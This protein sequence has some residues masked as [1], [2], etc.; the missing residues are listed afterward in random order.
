MIR[1]KIIALFFLLVFATELILPLSSYALTSGPDQPEFKSFSAAGT[2]ELVNTFTGDFNYDISLMDV[3]GYPL[4]LNYQSGFNQE[5]EASWVGAGWNL[6]TGAVTRSLRG[7]PDDF[8]GV[9]GQGDFIKKEMYT[10]PFQKVGGSLLSKTTL[11]GWELGRAQ[12]RVNFYKD[13]YYGIGASVGAGINIEIAKNTKNHLTADMGFSFSS[14]TRSG[15]NFSP[16]L[17]IE[18]FLEMAG[19]N[20]HSSKSLTGGFNYNSRQGL[21]DIY[22]NAERSYKDNDKKFKGSSSSQIK[23][24]G[25]SYTPPFQMDRTNFGLTFNFD[26][27]PNIFGF[28]VAPGVSA[29]YF[30]DKLAQNVVYTPAYGFLHYLEGAK[31]SGS[32]LDFN[33]EKDGV[34]IQAAPS[35]AIPIPTYDYFNVSAHGMSFQAK[36]YFPGNYMVGDKRTTSTSENSSVGVSLGASPNSILVGGRVEFISG[37]GESKFWKEDNAFYNVSKVSEASYG[38]DNMPFFLK[39]VG[40]KTAVNADFLTKSGGLNSSRPEFIATGN[41]RSRRLETVPK[42]VNKDKSFQFYSSSHVKNTPDPE[43]N[44]FTYLQASHVSSNGLDRAI[45]NYKVPGILSGVNNVD[46]EPYVDVNDKPWTKPHHIGEVTTIGDGGQRYI[47]GVPVYNKKQIDVTFSVNPPQGNQVEVGKKKGLVRYQVSANGKPQ[48]NNGRDH[49]Y[50]R[51]EI[52]GYATSFLLSAILSPDYVDLKNDG[53]TDDDLGTAIKFN[54]SRVHSDFKW[55]APFAPVIDGSNTY[56]NNVASYDPGFL[57]DPKDDKA[58]YTFGEKEIWHVHSIE[59]KNQIAFFYTSDR[60]DALGAIN[61][62]GGVDVS[63]K[64]KKLDKI[65]LYSKADWKNLGNNALPIKTVHFEYDYSTFKGMPNFDPAGATLFPDKGKLTLK[66]VYFTFGKN[67]RG[68]TNPYEFQ[69]DVRMVSTALSNAGFPS[70]PDVNQTNDLYGPMESDR[71][72]VFKHSW[73]NRIVSGV[74]YLENNEFPYSTQNKTLADLYASKWQLIG[75]TTP[76]FSKIS[77]NYESDDYS[78]VQDRRSMQMFFI[79]GIEE[80]PKGLIGSRYV[81]VRLPE[82]VSNRQDFINK[83]LKDDRGQVLKHIFFKCFVD[84]NNS[85]K[86]EFIHGY[87]EFDLSLFNSLSF[88]S[89]NLVNLPLKKIDNASPISISSWQTL[90]TSLPFFAY[91][92]YDNSEVSNSLGAM[93]AL[94]KS[95]SQIKDLFISPNKRA[96]NKR[97]ASSMDLKKSMVRLFSPS[98][99]KLGGGTRVKS[100]IFSDEWDQFTEGQGVKSSVG[101]FYDYTTVA[102]NGTTIS[103]GV[104]SYEPALGNEEN[105]FR[106]PVPF[107]DKGFWTN[108]Q[109][110]NIEMPLGETYFPSAGVGYSKVTVIPFGSTENGLAKPIKSPTGYNI[111]EYYTAKDF[112]TIVE[113]IP[114]QRVKVQTSQ[115]LRLFVG[116]YRKHIGFNQGMMIESNDMHGK[117]KLISYYNASGSLQTSTKYEY[118]VENENDSKKRLSNSVSILKPDGSIQNNVLVGTEVDLA[119]DFRVSQDLNTGISVG[120]YGGGINVFPVVIPFG[121]FIPWPSIADNL[122]N[123]ASMVKH[124]NKFGILKKVINNKNGS[125]IEVENLAFDGNT[126]VPLLTKTNDEYNK[127]LFSLSYPAYWAYPSMGSS[128]TTGRKFISTSSN[129][130]NGGD[131]FSIAGVKLWF[132]KGIGNNGMITANGNPGP[133]TYGAKPIYLRSGNRNMLSAMAGEVIM[134]K[135]PR[136]GNFIQLNSSNQI[137]DAKATT[138]KEEWPVKI[139]KVEVTYVGAKMFSFECMSQ[140]LS[141]LM[142]YKNYVSSEGKEISGILHTENEPVG[143]FDFTFPWRKSSS[144][145]LESFKDSLSGQYYSTYLNNRRFIGFYS[146]FPRSARRY[147]FQSGDFLTVG[148]GKI[149]FENV[150]TTE[151]IR[152]LN[153]NPYGNSVSNT[154]YNLLDCEEYEYQ[155]LVHPTDPNRIQLFRY[156]CGNSNPVLVYTARFEFLKEFRECVSPTNKVVNPY[157][158]GIHRNFKVHQEYVY[159][160]D[161]SYSNTSSAA[162]AKIDSKKSGYFLN[163]TPFWSYSAGKLNVSLNANDIPNSDSR[164]QWAMKSTRIDRSGNP[165]ESKDALNIYSAAHYGYNNSLAVAVV[166]GGDMLT[167]AYE[168]WEDFDFDFLRLNNPTAPCLF[169]RHMNIQMNKLNG[170]WQYV[171]SFGTQ[172]VISNSESHTGKFSLELMNTLNVP[173]KIMG[174]FNDNDPVVSLGNDQF[175]FPVFR[176]NRNEAINGF[177]LKNGKQYFLSFW[178]KTISSPSLGTVGSTPSGGFTVKLKYGSTVVDIPIKVTAN[179]EGWSQV[180]A[181]FF[182]DGTIDGNIEFN[183]NNG[184]SIFLDDLR[185]TPFNSNMKSFVYD[186]QSLRLTA[187]LD[188]NNFATIYEYSIDGVLQRVKKETDRGIMTIQET[189]QNLKSR[190]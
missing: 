100:I 106:E 90:H 61:E 54:Y 115:I 190:N 163:F 56:M 135:D 11:F 33:R 141:F 159:Q 105:P 66:K 140:F 109:Y 127:S 47:F 39:S 41:Y 76:S 86:F 147:Y 10:K 98:F 15:V 36:P 24:F 158:T 40:E 172:Y 178:L 144:I 43:V 167:S 49:Y 31:Y 79:E 173:F 27:G 93:R 110:H 72:G 118:F 119:T 169:E 35:I 117:Q 1:R 52:P 38:L 14:D 160:T 176:L 48:Y 68:Q 67:T 69:Y 161:R 150:N 92:A 121:S 153:G 95:V 124:V 3:D 123:S 16:T 138:Y 74:N 30:E 4:T 88:V 2:S 128:S 85:G 65:V 175:G 6:N 120:T 125:F 154:F 126:G 57:S 46:V 71:W 50:S 185:I 168:G 53:V 29:Y 181:Q 122:Y 12:T 81:K 188:E 34:F 187:E 180:Q 21:K 96:E 111:Y 45:L 134:A 58:N 37:S 133:I 87:G 107:V 177:S 151:V 83:Y 130:L 91:D 148:P 104:A 103:S 165:I 142:T 26:L 155:F 70:N 73:T 99:T 42:L 186:Q 114:L 23:M 164:W 183:I 59:S 62:H 129:S 136:V 166:K 113:A 162:N 131:E 64:L 145:C 149:F 8:R 182:F 5:E 9:Q 157:F 101:L 97:F 179:V 25:Q 152:L 171:N 139:Q 17:G 132:I 78:Y 19:E 20:N 174:N 80:N 170:Q 32:L 94:V 77:V 137:I 143:F 75:I 108:D 51:T 55:R 116:S 13:N 22:L 82:A 184:G 84:I 18:H 89:G 102:P 44:N 60:Y 189:K 146:F 156:S 7:L 28:E 112:P 63:K